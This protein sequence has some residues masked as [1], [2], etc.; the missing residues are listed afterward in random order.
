MNDANHT[1]QHA[2][3]AILDHAL[4]T[5]AEALATELRAAPVVYRTEPLSQTPMP[6]SVM[7]LLLL[8]IDS[9]RGLVHQYQVA[10]EE[11]RDSDPVF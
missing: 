6:F 9:L 5:L 11:E 2:T 8:H 10:L 1:Y 3:L 4:H 7:R